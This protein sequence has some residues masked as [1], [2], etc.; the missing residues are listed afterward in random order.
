MPIKK[1]GKKGKKGKKVKDNNEIERPLEFKSVED[2]QEYAQITK[3]LGNCR[4]SVLCVDGVERLAHIRGTMTK[5]KQWVKVGDLV[6]VSLREFEQSKCD[7]IYLYT[8]KEARRLKLLGEL[9][10]DI[11]IN[12]NIDLLEKEDEEDIGI[13]I[14]DDD[15]EKEIENELLKKEQFKNE[16]EDNFK[17]I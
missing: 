8:L 16:F 5:K 15:E 12:E 6:L 11:K 3:L 17:Y 14:I 1:G 10:N 7:V 13:D 4:C 2:N 9:P